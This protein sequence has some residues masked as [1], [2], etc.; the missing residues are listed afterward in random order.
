MNRSLRTA[1]GRLVALA[2]VLALLLTA[3]GADDTE[4]S[5]S[6]TEAAGNGDS[7]PAQPASDDP[8]AP[9][10]LELSRGDSVVSVSAWTY[11]W[12]PP[13]GDGGVC[14]DGAP[15]ATLKSLSG[16]GPITLRFGPDFTFVASVYD[17]AY[18]NQVGEAVVTATDDGWEIDPT[19]EGPSVLEVFGKGAEGDV[20]ISVA[21][22]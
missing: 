15:P 17:A 5:G 8:D 4:S 9:P 14:A 22:D 3:C 18:K 2:L 16:E 11:C 6:A 10:P 21:L 12:T 20:I 19:V 7:G 1:V 13:S